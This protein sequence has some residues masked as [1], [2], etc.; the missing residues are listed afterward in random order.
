MVD[1]SS[2][3]MPLRWDSLIGA[4]RP[5]QWT[6][7][8]VV[9]AAFF[10]ALG[11]RSQQISPAALLQTLAAMALFTLTA[12]G[13]YVFNDLRDRAHD[14]LHPVKCRRPI[15]AG[16][17]SVRAA[18]VL[19]TGC[20]T[21]GLLGGFLLQP[22]FALI[23]SIYVVLQAVY[24][25]YLKQ[26]HL[27][28][29]FMIAIGFVLRAVAGGLAAAVAISPWLVICT[30]LLALFLALCKRRHELQTAPQARPNLR[31]GSAALLDQLIAVTAGAVIV[32][33]A[34][35][36]QWPE[37]LAKFGTHQLYLTIPFVVFGVFRYLDL[38][39]NHDCG[40]QPE[41]LLLTDT[42]LLINLALFAVTALV[43]M[44]L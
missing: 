18:L 22:L 19:G 14:R 8:L 3:N 41:E 34:V 28:D 40:G 6:K 7:N 21:L 42:P 30:F 43:V 5:R 31:S 35:Y 1:A 11:D 36:T 12:G 15:A 26:V 39:Y 24:T 38:V 10:F 44:L 2:S 29:V 16:R 37:T 23:L 4:L 32:A 25:L 20:L 27:L 13:V 17:L 33:Y 9:L